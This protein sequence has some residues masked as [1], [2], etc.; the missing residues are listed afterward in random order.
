MTIGSIDV[1]VLPVL[2]AGQSLQKGQLGLAV[3]MVDLGTNAGE[4]FRDIRKGGFSGYSIRVN[5]KDVWVRQRF[6]VAH[7]LGHFLRHRNRVQNRLIDDRMYRSGHGKTVEYEANSLAAE[8]LM[9]RRARSSIRGM[10][11]SAADTLVNQR[12]R[13]PFFSIEDLADRVPLSR[14]NLAMLARIGALNN[15]RTD[16]KLNRRDTLWQV[17]RAVRKAGPLLEGI[18]ELNSVSPLR[19]MD[20]EER[21][22]ADYHGTGLT[23]GHHPM[24]YRR[25]ILRK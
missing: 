3:M 24:A 4:I 7:E 22:V 16:A 25:D 1:W 18:A 12:G 19:Q 8:L 10:Q 14:D 13:A 15:L 20:V 21:L 2:S 6:T 9:P 5:I 11:Q 23:T 17:E